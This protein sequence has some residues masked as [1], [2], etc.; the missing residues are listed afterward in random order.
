MRINTHRP[1]E[2]NYHVPQHRLE[3]DMLYSIS[4]W[5]LGFQ[6][7]YQTELLRQASDCWHTDRSTIVIMTTYILLDMIGSHDY[8]ICPS[9]LYLITTHLHDDNGYFY[10]GTLYP[11]MI[12][13]TEV[14]QSCSIFCSKTFWTRHNPKSMIV[15][16][17]TQE[18][19]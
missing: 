13:L 15:N 4:L 9:M 2:R 18:P 19:H 7:E 11:S 8:T 10:F 12:L 3:L 14:I 6:F 1:T 17:K 16:M 5:W